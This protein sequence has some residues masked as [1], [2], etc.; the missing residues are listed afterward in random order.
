VQARDGGGR[1]AG[2][3]ADLRQC[4]W[5]LNP[6]GCLVR[7]EIRGRVEACG[8][9][10]KIAAELHNPDLQL[11]LIADNVGVGMVQ[12]RLLRSHVL[13]ARLRV[14]DEPAFHISARVACIRGRHLASRAQVADELERLLVEYF[15]CR[16][17]D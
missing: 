4:S 8:V 16:S 15:R 14:V 2:K 1:T 13:R 10:F 17:A 5:V 6:P 9:P 12:E 7:D 11:A 3:L